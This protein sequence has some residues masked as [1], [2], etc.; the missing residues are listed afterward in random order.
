MNCD[1]AVLAYFPVIHEGYIDLFRRHAAPGMTVGILGEWFTHIKA[2]SYFRKDIRR[3]DTRDV[4][5]ML[6][7]LGVFERV[8]VLDAPQKFLLFN[9]TTAIVPRDHV[10]RVLQ[11]IYPRW[12]AKRAIVYETAF[13]MWDRMSV[14]EPRPVNPDRV[15]VHDKE[16]GRWMTLAF[17]EAAKSSDWWR[18]VGAV[19]VRDGTHVLSAHNQHFPTEHEPYH[20]GDARF[21]FRRGDRIDLTT[22][23]HAET[24]LIAAAA[25]SGITLS[26]CDLFVTT[27]PCPPCA[28]SV[29]TAGFSRIY[30]VSGYSMVEAEPILRSRGVELVRMDAVY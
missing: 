26:G 3:L 24:L 10:I 12:F 13:L 25:R 20:S 2:L 7:A 8:V 19:A 17:R 30:Y 23:G 11:E 18:R 16:A 22:A 9:P 29:V 15:A 5:D 28:I 6:R 4:A 14:E 27:F 1:K 21:A